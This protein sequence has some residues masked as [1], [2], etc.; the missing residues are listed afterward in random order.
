MKGS[1]LLVAKTHYDSASF[2]NSL[3]KTKTSEKDDLEIDSKYI[4]G[5][6]LYKETSWEVNKIGS[7][8]YDELIGESWDGFSKSPMFPDEK[9]EEKIVPINLIPVLTIENGETDRFVLKTENE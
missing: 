1:W 6:S 2:K 3:V 4:N 8:L 7:F 5:N 9:I